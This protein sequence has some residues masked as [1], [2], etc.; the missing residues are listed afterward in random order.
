VRWLLILALAACTPQG[1]FTESDCPTDVT[2]RPTYASFGSAF[3]TSYC[4]ACHSTTKSGTDRNGA[5]ATIDFDTESLVRDNTSDIDKQAAFGPKSQNEIMPP[6]G[7]PKPSASE[8]TQLG[9]FIACEV[10]N[11]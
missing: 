5:P 3:F 10:A 8:R 6:D 7:H 1:V 11:P 4:L 9:Q 2:M